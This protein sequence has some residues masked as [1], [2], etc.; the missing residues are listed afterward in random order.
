MCLGENVLGLGQFGENTRFCAVLVGVS[1]SVGHLE[2]ILTLGVLL[3]CYVWCS[4][5]SGAEGGASVN[6]SFPLA[7]FPVRF[8]DFPMIVAGFLQ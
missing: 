2:I 3:S 7:L 6:P 8:G 1:Y 4:Q 5:T